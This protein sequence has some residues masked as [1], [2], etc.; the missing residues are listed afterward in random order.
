MIFIASID[1]IIHDIKTGEVLPGADQ[2]AHGKE[3]LNLQL[4]SEPDTH[5]YRYTKSSGP[6]IP[7]PKMA[8]GEELHSLI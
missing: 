7:F 6:A 3:K 8:L 1:K 5:T 2:Q 4:K